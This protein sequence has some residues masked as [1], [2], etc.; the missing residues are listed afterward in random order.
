MRQVCVWS[1]RGMMG[2]RCETW[3]ISLDKPHGA[4]EMNGVSLFLVCLPNNSAEW[5]KGNGAFLPDSN[6]DSFNSNSA[7][8]DD[9]CLSRV[10]TPILK[11]TYLHYKIPRAALSKIK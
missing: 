11:L 5:R 6:T 1:D 2:R 8:A 7:Y 9:F 3:L 4:S 10:C